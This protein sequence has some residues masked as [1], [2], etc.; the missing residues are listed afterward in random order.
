V[1]ELERAHLSHGTAVRAWLQSQ[2]RFVKHR[3]I[4]LFVIQCND[5]SLSA[6]SLVAVDA[7]MMKQ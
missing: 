6:L 1:R 2:E 3:F 7:E 4:S 5:L